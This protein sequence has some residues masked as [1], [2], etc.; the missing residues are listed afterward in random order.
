MKIINGIKEVL[1]KYEFIVHFKI[2]N[3]NY[4][5]YLDDIVYIES[6]RNYIIIHTID[7]VAYKYKDSINKKEDELSKYG[8]ARFHESFLIN[9]KYIKS[10]NKNSVTVIQNFDIPVSR[11]R[12]QSVK[13]SFLE[14]HSRH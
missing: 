9:L 3:I 5:L 2:E 1:L 13:E 7:D 14:Y 4:K 8:F 6:K 10:I 11:Y 12:M